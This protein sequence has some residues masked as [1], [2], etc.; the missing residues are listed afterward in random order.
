M[1]VK[2]ALLHPHKA[3][4]EVKQI[5]DEVEGRE[6]R[7]EL[8]LYV[9]GYEDDPEETTATAKDTSD[10]TEKDQGQPEAA[11]AAHRE[12]PAEPSAPQTEE[13]T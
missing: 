12:P 11:G 3:P 9:V 8:N 7:F 2:T 4:K 1:T 13:T 5:F 10:A 6:E